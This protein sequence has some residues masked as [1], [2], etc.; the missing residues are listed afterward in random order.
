MQE[1]ML[2]HFKTAVRTAVANRNPVNG[3]WLGKG[4]G[5]EWI[6]EDSAMTDAY[7]NKVCHEM[8]RGPFAS[9]LRHLDEDKCSDWP[10]LRMT[11]QP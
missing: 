8:I 4:N 6:V 10:P 5:G 7:R 2:R 1:I 11:N 3:Y 9:F